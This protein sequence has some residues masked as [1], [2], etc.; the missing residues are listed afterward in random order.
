MI[1]VEMAG[2]PTC[3]KLFC[4]NTPPSDPAH[5]PLL[6]RPVHST[7]TNVLD[8]DGVSCVTLTEISPVLE[9]LKPC[10][11]DWPPSGMVPVKVSTWFC[12]GSTMPPQLAAPKAATRSA[13]RS[14]DCMPKDTSA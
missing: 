8:D 3:A 5:V 1:C 9:A 12:E 2:S 11:G 10:R 6:S 7:P 13:T 4:P 14:L